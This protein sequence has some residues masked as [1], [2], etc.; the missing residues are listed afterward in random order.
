MGFGVQLIGWEVEFCEMFVNHG[1]HLI[2]FDN[3]DI[4]LSTHCGDCEVDLAAIAKGDLTSVPY[5]LDDMADDAV[6]V[7]DELGIPAAHVLGTSMGGM[8]AQLTAIRH[9]TRVR[10]LESIMS[11]TG[12]RTV[13]RASPAALASLR[14]EV[15]DTRE[16][17]MEAA[18]QRGEAL[19]GGGFPF[20]GAMLAQRAAKAFDRSYDPP[21]RIRQQ[22]AVL[23]ARDRTVELGRITVPTVVIHGEADP[24]VDVSGGIATAKAIPNSKLVLIPGMGHEIPVEVRPLIVDEVIDNL[25]RAAARDTGQKSDQKL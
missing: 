9:P 12:D 16:G 17:N 24:L 23:S 4:G 18:I 11:T 20:D 6:A 5:T 1:L 21:S 15:D 7:L 8:I 25:S 14:I 22:A 10:S 3:R 2:R 13:G 19:R